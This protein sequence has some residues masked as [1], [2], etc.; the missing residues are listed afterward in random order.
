MIIIIII[1]IVYSRS[2][3]QWNQLSVFHHL[4]QG[5][6]TGL[7]ELQSISPVGK[8]CTSVFISTSINKESIRECVWA[9]GV[10]GGVRGAGGECGSRA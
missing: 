4:G 1:I 3:R 9:L 2:Q 5:F 10:W 8:C 7:K 6:L